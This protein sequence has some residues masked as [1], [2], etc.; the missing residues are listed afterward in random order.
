MF[1]LLCR[2]T[3]EWFAQRGFDRPVGAETAGL[4]SQI[5]W[6][7]V[8][9]LLQRGNK[10]SIRED[11]ANAF[12]REDTRA[13]RLAAEFDAVFNRLRV[14]PLPIELAVKKSK[15]GLARQLESVCARVRAAAI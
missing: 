11:T 12:V 3:R 8:W 7:W 9:P 13:P 14:R 5:T 15:K 1:V 4:L 10:H 2:R 6:S